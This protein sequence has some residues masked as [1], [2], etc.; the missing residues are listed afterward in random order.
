MELA[1][2][3]EISVSHAVTNVI[4]DREQFMQGAR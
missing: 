1:P 2:G 3:L 4:V